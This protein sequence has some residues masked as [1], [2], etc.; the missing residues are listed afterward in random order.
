LGTNKLR[1][2]AV[3]RRSGDVVRKELGLEPSA[4]TG[5]ESF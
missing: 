4:L 3:E 2:K 5:P 1:S